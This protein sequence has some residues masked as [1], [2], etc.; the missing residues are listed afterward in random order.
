M[1]S[2]RAFTNQQQ[3]QELF[4]D[5]LT[6]MDA[7]PVTKALA[8]ATDSDA[9]SQSIRNIVLTN[10]GERP[11]QPNIGSDVRASLFDPADEITAVRVADAIKNA[12]EYNEPRVDLLDVSITL[13]PNDNTMVATIVFSLINSRE[14]Q[15]L[16]IL[17]KR[18]R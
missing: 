6:N 14:P 3:R 7:H 9:V 5:F 15:R 12:V 16:D 17:L 10:L 2:T 13:G 11:F 18:V 8:R 4:S 1:S